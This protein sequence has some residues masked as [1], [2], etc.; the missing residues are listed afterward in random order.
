M[1][2]TNPRLAL[3][4]TIA[5]GVGG[6]AV[7]AASPAGAQEGSDTVPVDVE[8]SG[9]DRA[10]LH[11][12]RTGGSNTADC[13][14]FAG[15][16][17]GQTDTDADVGGLCQSRIDPVPDP[18][19]PSS[20][21]RQIQSNNTGA[22]N[23]DGATI[24]F[25]L[26]VQPE[27]DNIDGAAYPFTINPHPEALET[28]FHYNSETVCSETL[29]GA[30]PLNIRI[31]YYKVAEADLDGAADSAVFGQPFAS[32]VEEF[33]NS[34]ST[35]TGAAGAT[36]VTMSTSLDQAVTIQRD[37]VLVTEFL[38]ENAEA[39]DESFQW[40]L[41]FEDQDFDSRTVVR[42]DEVVEQAVWATDKPGTQ[43]N[44]F[45]P[46]ASESNRHL[47]PNTALRSPFGAE[48]VPA[49][50]NDVSIRGPSESFVDLVT[51]DDATTETLALDEIED[52]SKR[53]GAL[54]LFEIEQPEDRDQPWHYPEGV[55][56]GPYDI[57][58]DSQPIEDAVTFESTVAMGAF[59]FSMGPVDGESTNHLVQQ[60]N[61]TTFLLEVTNEGSDPDSY[62]VDA[63]FQFSEGGSQWSV[64]LDRNNRLTVDPGETELLRVTTTPPEDVD[65]G[66]RA[67]VSVAAES[68]NSGA[69]D[70]LTLEAQVTDR[71]IRDVGA[72][73]VADQPVDVGIDDTTRLHV[74][75]WNQGT[76]RDGMSI[77]LVPNS[78]EG[79][80]PDLFEVEVAQSEVTGVTP[81]DI[82]RVPIDV[83]TEPGVA[84]GDAFSFEIRVQSRAQSSVSATIGVETVVDAERG[85]QIVGLDHQ[86]DE[87]LESLRYSRFNRSQEDVSGDEVAGV[88]EPQLRGQPDRPEE[89]K[90]Y[91]NWTYHRAV[92][93]NTGDQTE[94]VD[95]SILP[96]AEDDGIPGRTESVGSGPTGCTPILET[97]MERMEEDRD[98]EPVALVDQIDHGNPGSEDT[99][100]EVTLE[101]DETD[102]VY[103][104]MGYDGYSPYTDDVSREEACSQESYH[105]TVLGSLEDGA[106]KRLTTETVFPFDNTQ[107]MDEDAQARLALTDDYV[108]EDG[109]YASL[110]LRTGLELGETT[111]IN[112]T[113]SMQQGHEDQTTVEIASDSLVESLESDGWDIRLVSLGAEADRVDEHELVIPSDDV[114]QDEQ[115][116]GHASGVDHKLG[117]EVTPP[118]SGPQQNERFSF[119]MLASSEERPEES[120]TV[121]LETQIGQTF[122][123]DVDPGTQF[124]R[125]HPGDEV[126]FALGVLNEGATRD[127]YDVDVESSS[128]AVTVT[129]DPD[130][131]EISSGSQQTSAIQVD[132]DSGATQNEEVTVTTT[133]TGER[134]TPGDTSDDVGP[135]RTEYTID[136]QP[137]STLTMEADRSIVSVSPG[138]QSAVTFSITNEKDTAQQLESSQIV[139]PAGWET[140]LSDANETTPIAG[141]ET[142]T[143][144]VLLEAPDSIVEGSTFPFVIQ[145]QNQTDPS[146][147]AVAKAEAV[148][149]GQTALSLQVE[150]N[151]TEVVDRG[152]TAQFP[153]LV[154]NPGTSPT[155]YQLSTSF[156]SQDWLS[157]FIDA[158]SGNV[159][160]NETVTVPENEFRRVI[161]EVQS[162]NDVER[163]Y[164]EDL[165]VSAFAQGQRS[166][167]DQVE[168]S[169]AI[170]DF[171]VEID[172]TGAQAK[173][174][175]P[176]DSVPFQVSITNTGNGEDEISLAFFGP[177][178]DEPTYPVTSALTE[179]ETP[180]LA[181]GETLE[182]VTVE[183]QIPS[184]DPENAPVSREDGVTT[185]IEARSGGGLPS[186]SVPTATAEVTTHLV[187]YVINDVDGDGAFEV[188][189]DLNRDLA[190]GYEVFHDQDVQLIERGELNSSQSVDSEG[191]YV[192][193]GDEDDR[194]EHVIDTDNDGVGDVYLDPDR[195]RTYEIPFAVDVT[196]DGQAEHPLDVDFD[197]VV[198]GMF[199]PADETIRKTVHVDL[200]GDGRRDLLVDTDGDTHY[201]RFVDPHQDPALVTAVERDG[202][203][204]KVDTD[205]S[206]TIDTHYN[207]ETQSV[208]DAESANLQ[209]FLGSYWYVLVV[210]LA[211][212]VAFG[213]I[214]YRRL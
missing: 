133:V 61:S 25:A 108:R 84:E 129:A 98:V 51:D 21:T 33:C 167:T 55:E 42:T 58:V 203:L 59:D 50:G 13:S 200:S 171:G 69:E 210:F 157:R 183:V 127:V 63:E 18:E 79:D 149:Q 9:L 175:G 38:A 49:S 123:F 65:V 66:D 126:A 184:P 138:G 122:D 81:G 152:G 105:A 147:F 85:L 104:R 168:L 78:T 111:T 173:D 34:G 121:T 143:Q 45:D 7:F 198:D 32:S 71:T 96:A 37:E 97:R 166:V 12:W 14:V 134:G 196:G 106:D 54:K 89:C 94:T 192:V 206:G 179:D 148:A 114:L 177:E 155:S 208:Q 101:P 120:D 46:N 117:L 146:E 110:P 161:V 107:D 151:Q 82:A 131:P 141:G 214:F 190:D 5:L 180:T 30:Q 73:M 124:M 132:I 70:N 150:R 205:G 87:A 64:D 213:V 99:L 44:S 41:F 31:R 145:A 67:R 174:V 181:P 160:S 182:N 22:E 172:V 52:L 137:P 158:D 11:F 194:A 3:L 17:D 15:A 113:L 136:V 88:C 169:A 56:A 48:A 176:G 6:V 39:G 115:S 191:L 154:R 118:E 27:G 36:E 28:T 75:A 188:A 76:A 23:E 112:F 201:E 53:N 156:E 24:R 90:D 29:P 135:I 40:S 2:R 164:V 68:S 211:V 100:S 159:L 139:G 10:E 186:G 19:N 185:I 102:I 91:H 178:N 43:R 83:T 60:G 197:G 119:T 93:T 193:D 125:A 47:V 77:S 170:H 80:N 212:V 95:L 142:I 57:V 35:A 26:D 202:D 163:G 109:S 4:L 8:S 86:N 195:A 92:V 130:D 199:D 74:S 209:S 72:L 153:I 128:D 16:D 140:S 204:Y 207:V 103:L 144:T 116:I 162:P 187:D 189:L 62:T 165:T 1:T 20:E